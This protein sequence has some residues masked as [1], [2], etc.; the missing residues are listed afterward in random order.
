MRKSITIQTAKG[1]AWRGVYLNIAGRQ[2]F[3]ATLDPRDGVRPALTL[4]VLGRSARVPMPYVPW[5][6]V[7]KHGGYGLPLMWLYRLSRA[8]WRG[9]DGRYGWGTA[10][11]RGPQS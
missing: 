3:G 5:R 6:W 4:A 10:A 11:S 9:V 7:A 8:F 1:C 2:A